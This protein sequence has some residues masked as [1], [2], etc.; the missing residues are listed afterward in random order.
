ME[1]RVKNNRLFLVGNIVSMFSKK[2]KTLPATEPKELLDNEALLLDVRTKDEYS[3]DHIKNSKN[4]PLDE[5]EKSLHQLNKEQHIIVVCAS[6]MRS[7]KAVDLMKK[8][9]FT[10]CYSGG[11]WS[12]YKK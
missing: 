11:C 5:L 1:T 7:S 6:G 10:C 9:G 3:N 12:N 4:I 8:N 2:K